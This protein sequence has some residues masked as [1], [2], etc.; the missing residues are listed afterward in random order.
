[1]SFI[2]RGEHYKAIKEK[3]LL[4]RMDAREI[5]INPVQVTEHADDVG[6]VDVIL[7]GVKAWQVRSAGEALRPM[8]GGE[9]VVIPLQNGIEAA[10]ELSKIL[11]QDTSSQGPAA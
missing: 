10:P 2:A 1:M 7:L 4:L 6:I 5:R 9:T 11:D 8:I 3:G